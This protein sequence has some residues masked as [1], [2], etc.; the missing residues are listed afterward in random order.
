MGTGDHFGKS[1]KN[2]GVLVDNAYEEVEA[3]WEKS[4]E[5][6]ILAGP[7]LQPCLLMF[8]LVAWRCK[9]QEKKL[10]ANRKQGYA[11]GLLAT[12]SPYK[13]DIFFLHF[14]ERPKF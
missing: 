2:I 9:I 8:S 5:K 14:L 1:K 10:P 13:S 11:L 12:V 7:S 3:F 4:K 6:F